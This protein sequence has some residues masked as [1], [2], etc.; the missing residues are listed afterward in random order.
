MFVEDIKPNYVSLS[1]LAFYR[2][3]IIMIK[4]S[5][6]YQSAEQSEFTQKKKYR[7]EFL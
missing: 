4:M 5:G 2:F 6:F 3:Y 1:K 7:K